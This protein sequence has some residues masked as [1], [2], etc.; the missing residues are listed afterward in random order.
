[1]MNIINLKKK[2]ITGLL[3][4]ACM[5]F[6]SACDSAEDKSKTLV[7]YDGQ[8]AEMRLMHQ[9]VKILV[10]DQTDLKVQIKDEMSPVNSFNELVK[11]N[12]DLMNSYDGT[13]LTTFLH[14]DPS[15][16]P[17]GVNLYDFVN[18]TASK[19]KHVHLLAKL[20]LNNTYAVAVPKAIAE[21]YHLNTISDLIPVS[22]N[23][24]F[25]A[26]HEFF[27]EEGSAK[28]N[29]FVSFYGLKFK[30][31]KPI[32][33]GLKYSA[34]QSGN[35]DVTV[36]YATDGLNRKAGLKILKDD[37]QFFPEYNGALLVRDD[38][39]PRMAD[40]AP[41]LEEVLNKLGGQLSDEIMT[42]LSYAVD[43]EGRSSHDVA[44]EFLQKR[45]LLSK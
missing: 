43:V 45:G 28:F 1:M 37:R 32:D 44:Q 21:K 38:L 11:G 19:E 36:T 7:I 6:L 9:M 41:N 10:E 5:A 16:V 14:L 22:Q 24:V 40:V 23:L 29:P 2:W 12:A 15:Q 34:V 35:I 42:D 17:E 8:F 4:L 20:G 25:G 26:E 33:L 3:V 30:E 27:S 18:E 13:L 31:S 39:M